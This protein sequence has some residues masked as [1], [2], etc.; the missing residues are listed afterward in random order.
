MQV[1]VQI[2]IRCKV[3]RCYK[4]HIYDNFN[5]LPQLK[6][7]IF[8][9]YTTNS[10]A[11]LIPSEKKIKKTG[12]ASWSKKTFNKRNF[13]STTLRLSIFK[14]VKDGCQGKH[15]DMSQ[16]K[17]GILLIR[18]KRNIFRYSHNLLQSRKLLD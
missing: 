17:C 1:G 5:K 3:E 13:W 6:D 12:I 2:I 16:G 14:M 15:Y 11:I 10:S 7:I 8:G 18:R 4:S 9:L